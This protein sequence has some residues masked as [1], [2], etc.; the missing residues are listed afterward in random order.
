MNITKYKIAIGAA[1]LNLIL[2]FFA[3]GQTPNV[4]DIRP[5]PVGKTVEREIK[6]SEEHF[7]TVELN[8]GEVLRFELKEVEDIN[9]VFRL[10]KASDGQIIIE[11]EIIESHL[12]QLFGR[13]S[14]TYIAS[15]KESLKVL[16]KGPDKTNNSAKYKL[17]VTVSKRAT[18]LT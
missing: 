2:A 13:E 12:T 16:I 7:Y 6:A 9:Y 10:I 8:E 18:E 1:A 4:T 17:T 5:L 15:A 14:I 11:S 3:F